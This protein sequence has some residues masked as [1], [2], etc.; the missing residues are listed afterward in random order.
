VTA[1]AQCPAPAR[2]VRQLIPGL[3]HVATIAHAHPGEA[4]I[5]CTCQGLRTAVDVDDP[6][7]LRFTLW[8]HLH[9]YVGD[10]HLLV[11]D[12]RTGVL[13]AVTAAAEPQIHLTLTPQPKGGAR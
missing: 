10:D 1:T 6:Q 2:D 5:T 12:T 4:L 11:D 9:R 7:I 8:E 3:R 13:Y